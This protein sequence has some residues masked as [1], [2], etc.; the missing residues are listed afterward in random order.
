MGLEA[1]KGDSFKDIRDKALFSV[2]LYS[3][4]RVSALVTLKVEDYYQRKGE[5][6]LRLQEK[7]GKIHEV[8]VHSKARE[9]VDQ[10]LLASGLGSNPSAPLFP[11]FGNCPA[12]RRTQSTFYNQNLRQMRGST[13]IDGDAFGKFEGIG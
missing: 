11:A 3:W 10:W 9:A 8:P 5:R 2:L 6:W 1:I 7:R 4:A 12:H 13:V